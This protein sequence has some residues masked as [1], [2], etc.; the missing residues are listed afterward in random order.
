MFSNIKELP[1]AILSN[2]GNYQFRRF[3]FSASPLCIA[4]KESIPRS[5][6]KKSL[7]KGESWGLP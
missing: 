4:F 6:K 7:I 3:N 2:I 1:L 5:A